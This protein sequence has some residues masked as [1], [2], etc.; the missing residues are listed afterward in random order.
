MK[1]YLLSVSVL[2]LI[3]FSAFGQAKEAFTEKEIPS[4]ELKTL[5]G[6]SVNI[7]D[8][9]NKGKITILSFW[10]TWC[11][12]CKQELNNIADLYEYWQ[13]DYNMELIAISID[14]SR[15]TGKVKS[16]VNGS[17]WDYTILLDQN[18]DLQRALNFQ[19]PPYTILIDKNGKIISAH[20]GYKP[21]DEN[22]LEDEMKELIK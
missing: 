16:M 20:S 9:L 18:R 21:G 17:A 22:I 3:N 2:I 7:R 10:A 6:E 13:E 14:D 8:Y 15:N 12:P 19:M 11:G 5:S 4:I 1:S